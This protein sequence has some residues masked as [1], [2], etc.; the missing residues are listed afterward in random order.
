LFGNFNERDP[1]IYYQIDRNQGS[2]FQI[3]NFIPNIH[4]ELVDLVPH[5]G[6]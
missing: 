3:R 5:Y 4:Y 2:I 6:T 1:M